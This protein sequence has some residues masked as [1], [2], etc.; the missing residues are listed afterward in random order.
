MV[1]KLRVENG[2]NSHSCF[3]NTHE[4]VVVD[5][6]GPRD[7]LRHPLKGQFVNPTAN[8]CTKSEV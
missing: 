5:T 2:F 1:T 6:N 3:G 4:Q 7:A 8:Q